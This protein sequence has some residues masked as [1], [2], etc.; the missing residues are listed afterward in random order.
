[1]GR[2]GAAVRAF[3]LG[4]TVVVVAALSGLLVVPAAHAAAGAGPVMVVLDASGSMADKLPE[5][6][7]KI[8]AAKAAVHT[9]VNQATDGARLGL[10]VYGPEGSDS[11]S[12]GCDRVKVVRDVGPLDRNAFNAAV[13]G[14]RA[15]G[16]T[17]IGR[18]LRTAASALPGDGPRSIVLVSDG[19]DT[20]APPDPCEVAEELAK[21]G[22]DLRIHAVGFDVDNK[23]RE[24]LTCI[25]QAAGGR[26][27]DA[28]DAAALTAALN[29]LAEPPGE[30]G[31]FSKLGIW[32]WVAVAVLVVLVG[33]AVVLIVRRRSRV[34][35]QPQYGPPPQYGQ[36]P[37]HGQ[38]P[39]GP[40]G[41]WQP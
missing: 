9:L 15:R 34:A 14:I 7:T 20:C 11:R 16:D 27:V 41:Y 28:K 8:D 21:Q 22:I 37:Q 36:P 33:T 17:P 25:A 2:A 39:Q 40:G 1:M 18:S 12:S 23:A 24:E 10:T 19:K 29:Q 4:A 5:G 30:A 38:P 3:G 32:L 26:Y 35:V 6:G 31:F 13:D